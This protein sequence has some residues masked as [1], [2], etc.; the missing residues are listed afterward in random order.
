MLQ[1]GHPEI[2]AIK[3]DPLNPTSSGVPSA[4]GKL[5]LRCRCCRVCVKYVVMPRRRLSQTMIVEFGHAAVSGEEELKDNR[6]ICVETK[7]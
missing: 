5:W 4:F 7:L 1:I 2:K 3:R 6:A